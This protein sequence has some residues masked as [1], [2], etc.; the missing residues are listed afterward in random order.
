MVYFR[1]LFAPFITEFLF[2]VCVVIG[3]K[4]TKADGLVTKYW[5]RTHLIGAASSVTAGPGGRAV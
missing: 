3:N 5:P 4:V 1:T 2:P